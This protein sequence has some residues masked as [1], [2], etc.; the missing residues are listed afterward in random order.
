LTRRRI[1]VFGSNIQGV[2]SAGAA[3]YARAYH[4]ARDG[5]SEGLAGDS[6]A[7]PTCS[8]DGETLSPLHLDEI[9]AAV[10]RFYL[11]AAH[12]QDLD[13]LVTS[14][15]C[16]IGGYNPRQIGKFFRYFPDNVYL[17]AKLISEGVS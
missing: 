11:F 16:G 12:R 3:A 8:W 4:G 2:H 7:I 5:V 10:A 15:A 9:R 14:L 13:F 1:F 6:Y 17:Q